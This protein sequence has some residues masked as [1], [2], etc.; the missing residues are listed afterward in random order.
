MEWKSDSPCCSHTYPGW[1]SG[2][3]LEFRDCGA[4]PGWG[5]LLTGERQI[6]GMWVWS[7]I[8][9]S[10]HVNGC[11]CAIYFK[12]S[13]QKCTVYENNSHFPSA[14]L[15]L[16]LQILSVSV[17]DRHPCKM[18]LQK[19]IS[20]VNNVVVL[21]WM[22]DAETDL[23]GQNNSNIKKI[24]VLLI[25]WLGSPHCCAD[26]SLAAAKALGAAV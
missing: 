1:C 15:S 2:W 16:N 26:F 8:C 25:Y 5:L 12:P 24:I 19:W 22:R 7:L 9:C 4:I 14:N 23:G 17:L 11:K 18:I 10:K 3:E 6:E 13:L 20:T 21:D